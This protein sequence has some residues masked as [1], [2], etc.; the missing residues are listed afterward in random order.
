MGARRL[1]ET[2]RVPN[3]KLLKDATKMRKLMM[4]FVLATAWMTVS[5]AIG[6]P[7]MPQCAPKCPW[8]R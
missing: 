3:P 6:A 5:S 8:I 7:P 2:D 4:I 1:C